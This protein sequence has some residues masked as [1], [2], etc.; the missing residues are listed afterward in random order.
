[1]GT[2][3]HITR[4]PYNLKPGLQDHCTEPFPLLHYQPAHQSSDEGF[5]IPI[6]EAISKKVPFIAMNHSGVSDIIGHGVNGYLAD[7]LTE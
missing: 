5:G 1:M 4:I 2:Y 6:L 7:N 3:L